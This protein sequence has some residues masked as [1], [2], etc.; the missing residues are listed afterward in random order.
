MPAELDKFVNQG[1]FHGSIVM[2]SVRVV[3]SCVI[4]FVLHQS[5]FE[6]GRCGFI[7]VHKPLGIVMAYSH[8]VNADAAVFRVVFD[9]HDCFFLVGCY[10]GS[11]Q[12]DGESFQ[13]FLVGI[14]Y[15]KELWKSDDI[16][17]YLDMGWR[18]IQTWVCDFAGGRFREEAPRFVLG[19][20]RSLGEPKFPKSRYE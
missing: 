7:L 17:E 6:S 1:V 9:D 16:N 14:V 13:E 19:W 10:I 5:I 18:I 11:M 15:V 12:N 4:P 3:R 20:H 8:I 2:V